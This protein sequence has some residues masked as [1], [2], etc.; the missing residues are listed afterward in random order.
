MPTVSRHRFGGFVL[1]LDR[2]RLIDGAGEERV[3]RAKSFLVLRALAERAGAVVSKDELAREVWPDVIASDDTIAH[4]VS[5]IR[6]ALGP[7]GARHIRTMPRR[8]YM[9]APEAPARAAA[10]RPP[11]SWRRAALAGPPALALAVALAF[12]ALA[13]PDPTPSPADLAIA[14]ADTLLRDPDWTRRSDNDRAR[15]LLEAAAVAAPG[16]ARIETLRAL[17][18]WREVRHLPWGGGRREM[19]RALAHLEAAMAL[20]GDPGAHRLLAEIR[21]LSPFPETR[22]P[23]GALAAARAAVRL[24]PADAASHAT[25]AEALAMTGRAEDARA[26]IAAAR[27]LDPAPPRRFAYIAGLSHLL[28]GAPE[29]AAAAFDDFGRTG[30][31]DVER[32]WSGWLHA[33]SLA[34][35]GR[36]AD[37]AAVLAPARAQ[38]PDLSAAAAATAFDGLGDSAIGVILDGLRRAGLPG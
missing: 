2:G 28:A 34:Q 22:D 33:A 6:R 32:G 35:A 29:E 20:G 18:W 36:A 7:E 12:F 8:G 24:A 37:A 30:A 31:A 10:V 21:L 19:D 14:Q 17:T 26:E 9:F 11:R 13:P 23:L 38:R 15:A 5:D 25:L 3:L 1:D 16:D 27:A 4:C